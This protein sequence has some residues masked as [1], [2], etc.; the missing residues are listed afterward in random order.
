MPAGREL[1][2]FLLAHP[3]GLR[4]EILIDRLWPKVDPD[5]AASKLSNTLFRLRRAVGN[6]VIVHEDQTYRFNRGLDYQYDVERFQ[7]LIA[8]T[9]QTDQESEKIRYLQEATDLYGGPYLPELDGQWVLTERKRLQILFLNAAANLAELYLGEDRLNLAISVA[10]QL[11][12][13]DPFDERGYRMLMRAH[14]VDGN[15]AEIIRV[16]ERCRLLL[17]M[18]LGVEPS[19]QTRSLFQ[20]LSQS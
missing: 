2:F 19:E 11:L 4:R 8:L 16:Y 13:A 20:A 7:N 15:R 9:N 17:E 12:E 14:A 5:Q 1:L 18:E 10:L 6:E 3:R